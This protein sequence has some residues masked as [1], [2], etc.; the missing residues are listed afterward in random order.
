MM[1][2]S[3]RTRY[4]LRAL[5]ALAA[6]HGSGPLS[7]RAIAADQ[8]LPVK[9]LERLFVT[10]KAAGL[11]MAIRG[12]GGGYDRPRAPGEAPLLE[13]F[14]V[15]EG[16]P[17]PVECLQPSATCP[18]QG[19]CATRDVWHEVSQAVSGVLADHSLADLVIEPPA[20]HE[21]G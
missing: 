4:G 14:E 17:D 15:L 8:H 6:A 20:C 2:V 16:P 9:Y 13:V 7:L 3:T 12:A 10:L 21:R 1:K 18:R 11:V 19:A 5:G